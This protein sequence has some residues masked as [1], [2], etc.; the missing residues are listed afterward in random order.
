MYTQLFELQADYLKALAQPRR[1]E[2]VNLLREQELNVTQIYQML[3][4][5]QANVS[6]HLMVL[7]E[8]KILDLRKT[9]KHIY[10]RLSSSKISQM[11]DILREVLIDQ[12]ADSD[13]ADELTYQMNDLVPVTHDPVCKMRV[14]PKTAAFTHLHGTTRYYFCASGCLKQFEKQPERY[15]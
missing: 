13:L 1:L 7:K 8:S 10:Y 15:V 6:Q 9:G 2:I 5:P 11:V 4:L 3:D 12:Y 14:S